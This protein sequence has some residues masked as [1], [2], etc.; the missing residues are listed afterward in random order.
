MRSSPNTTASHLLRPYR[1][2]VGRGGHVFSQGPSPAWHRWKRIFCIPAE[3]ACGWD[4]HGVHEITN[5]QCFGGVLT[6]YLVATAWATARRRDAKTGIL[7][8]VALL[9][10]LALGTLVV[11]YGGEAAN[12][13]TRAKDGIPAGMYFFL[14]S[15]ALLSAAGDVRMLWHLGVSG[16]QRIARHL[17]R[18]CF[19]V[20]IASSSLFLARPQLF[21]A[22]L[23]KTGIVFL[24]GVLPL[25]LMIFWLVRVLFTNAFKRTLSPNRVLGNRPGVP[26]ASLAC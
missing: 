8:W 16:A 17:W 11:T 15:V 3:Y 21:P 6:F 19:A 18:M 13:S 14:G 2:S 23:R 24:L 1:S 25:I 5:E 22:L 26:K 12:S 9:V 7:D 4:L 10:A 20:S